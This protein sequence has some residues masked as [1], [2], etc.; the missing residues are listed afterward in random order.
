MKA[1]SCL[2]SEKAVQAL[3]PN[4]TMEKRENCPG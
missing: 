3:F 2:A 4:W 1:M